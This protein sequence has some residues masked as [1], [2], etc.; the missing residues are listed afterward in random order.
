[1]TQ[2]QQES[3]SEL[4]ETDETSETSVLLLSQVSEFFP[5]NSTSEKVRV[6]AK[7]L[8]ARDNPERETVSL[9]ARIN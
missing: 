6:T 7:T 5:G 4:D 3:Q 8:R 2:N 1:M 9:T